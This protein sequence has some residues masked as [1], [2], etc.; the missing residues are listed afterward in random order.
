MLDIIIQVILAIFLLLIMGFLAYSIY[1]REYIS[2]IKI[3]TSNRKETKIFSGIYEYTSSDYT[4]DTVNIRDPRY[5]DLSPSVNQ[6]GGAEYSY[7]FWLYYNIKDSRSTLI[8]GRTP[9]KKYIVL[10]YKGLKNKLPY[11]Q[12]NYS[13]DTNL[14]NISKSYILVK[15]PLVKLSND[16]KHLIVEYNNI[17]TPDTFNSSSNKLDCNSSSIDIYDSKNNKLGIKDMDNNLFN[18]TYNMVTIVMQESPKGED[19]LFVNRT[20]CKV[21][22]NGTLISNRSTLNNDLANENNRD[23]YTTVMRKNMG[24]LY[25]NPKTQFINDPDF[26]S[27]IQDIIDS[28]GVT[29]DAPLKVADLTYFNYALTEDDVLRLYNNKFNTNVIKEIIPSI[30]PAKIVIGDRINN[31]LYDGDIKDTVPVKSI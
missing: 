5:L 1:D 30:D 24:Y 8:D 11:N 2:S 27:Q 16:G 31:D 6:N 19:E 14:K 26:V 21:Y 25:I 3:S 20:T 15:N 28:D 29:K 23:S 9:D 10:F 18:K 7:N 4:I 17:N 22:L 12:F 13:C